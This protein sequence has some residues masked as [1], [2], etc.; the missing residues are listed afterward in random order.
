MTT[1]RKGQ[2]VLVE[3]TVIAWETGRPF[4]AV[5]VSFREATDPSH[6]LDGVEAVLPQVVV[7]TLG[8]EE[9]SDDDPYYGEQYYGSYYE[10][11]VQDS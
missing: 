10:G 1:Y 5:T 7:H 4:G 6:L 2:K 9:P 8:V 11:Q 3:G